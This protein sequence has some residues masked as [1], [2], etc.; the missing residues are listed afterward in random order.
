MR[1]GPT[2]PAPTSPLTDSNRRPLPYH[3]SALPTELRGR[4]P[5]RLAEQARSPDCASRIVTAVPDVPHVPNPPGRAARRRGDPR[6]L[7]RR[8]ARVDGHLRP[9]CPARSTTRSPG[10]TS[11]RAGT[12]RSWRSTATAGWSA[13]R[14][15]TPFRP[16]PAYATTVEDSVY[17]RRD[18]RGAGVGRSAA[19]RS[20]GLARD[21][22]FHSVIARIVGRPRRL[23]RAA[24]R[25]AASSRSG[26]SAEVGR[27]FGRWLDVVVMQKML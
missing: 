24:P 3:G 12:R 17:V 1:S 23:D 7:Q 25:R 21:H 2:G 10:S 14:S 20:R 11:T 8:G 6:D 19:R 22:G 18:L 16:R 26:A 27:K 13:S 4:S 9:A 5:T 15:L